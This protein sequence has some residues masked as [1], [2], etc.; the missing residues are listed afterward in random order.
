[1]EKELD[2]LSKTKKNFEARAGL[3]KDLESMSAVCCISASCL[4]DDMLLKTHIGK[5]CADIGI[6]VL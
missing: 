2:D 6:L 4:A 3:A 5:K 1:M